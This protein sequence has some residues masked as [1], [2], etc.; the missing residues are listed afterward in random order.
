MRDI[1]NKIK[2]SQIYQ[3][4]KKE[5]TTNEIKERKARRKQEELQPELKEQRLKQNQQKTLET[6][7]EVDETIVQG[8]E[9][10]E[11][12]EDEFD[13]YFKNGVE[14]KILITTSRRCPGPVYEFVD[15]FVGIFPN[16]E[17][18]K[19]S[20]QF[21][22]K[23]IIEIANSR[24]YTG[25][26]NLIPDLIIVNHDKK[27]PNAV[28]IV[29]LPEGP[30]AH[31]K[32]SSIKLNNNIRGHGKLQDYKPELILNNFTTRLGHTIGKMFSSLFP[33]QP[34]F[35]GRQAVTIHNQRDFIFFRRHRYVFRNGEKV[36]IQEIGPRFT[37]KLRWLQNGLFDT[38]YGVF[39]WVHKPELDTSRRKFHL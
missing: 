33:Q 19:R 1:K 7:R 27:M 39:E 11:E 16:A 5:K 34:D 25:N 36:D 8:D 12:A 28:T 2:R 23:K 35:K 32:L 26:L 15:E 4:L 18:V 37:L 9:E 14:P 22:I 20:S 13:G 3:K 17:F 24:N 30:T 6:L 21:E 38:K 31:F 10:V 29:H